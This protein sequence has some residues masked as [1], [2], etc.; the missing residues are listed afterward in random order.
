MQ[1]NQSETLTRRSFYSRMVNLMGSALGLAMAVPS[2]VYL[3]F[4]GHGKG[5]GAFVEAAQLSQL[6]IGTPKQVTFARTRVDGWRTF[7]EKAIAWVV[8]TGEKDAVAYSPQCTHLGCAYHWE[9]PRDR[10]VC[11]CHESLFTI[12]GKVTGGPAARPLDRYAV[13]VE[14][15]RLMIGSEIKKA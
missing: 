9:A 11:P 2:A 10:F 3:L 4:S 8:R 1:M 13:K 5:R 15:D 12:D 14:N 7:E 6:E